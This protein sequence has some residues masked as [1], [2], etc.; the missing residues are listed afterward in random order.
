MVSAPS[1]TVVFTAPEAP[2]VD[3]ILLPPPFEEWDVVSPELVLVSDAEA[4]QRARAELPEPMSWRL[5]AAVRL[6]AAAD[7]PPPQPPVATRRSRRPMRYAV[8]AVALAVVGYGVAAFTLDGSAPVVL[9]PTGTESSTHRS[10]RAAP[11]SRAV[12][13]TAEQVAP[14]A[15]A[16]VAPTSLAPARS[17]V[18]TSSAPRATEPSGTPTGFVPARTWTW[19]AVPGATRYVVTFLRNGHPVFQRHVRH[20][21]LKLPAGFRFFTG[22]YRWTVS[23]GGSTRH[24]VESS[25]VLNAAQAAAANAST[26]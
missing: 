12:E 5:S 22:T 2:P 1:P 16:E 10:G 20:P 14:R 23:A 24:I 11:T 6:R 18:P 4:A 9:Q 21:M 8:A 26:R 13:T 7:V 17:V 19:A 15:A 3:P 25:F